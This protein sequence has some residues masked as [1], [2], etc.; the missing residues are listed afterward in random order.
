MCGRASLATEPEEPRA[1]LRPLGVHVEDAAGWLDPSI[2]QNCV[3]ELLAATRTADEL[4][5]YP[6]D[7]VRE[8]PGPRGTG[9]LGADGSCR[10]HMRLDT[11]RPLR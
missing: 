2:P 6:V 10:R 1:F 7:H 4:Q 3:G 5:S 8:P 11:R 9:A